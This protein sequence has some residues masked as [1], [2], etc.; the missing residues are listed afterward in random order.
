MGACLRRGGGSFPGFMALLAVQKAEKLVSNKSK[1]IGTS[2]GRPESIHY[3]VGK[4]SM[5]GLTG[6]NPNKS[7]P[8]KSKQA[9]SKLQE[10]N[11]TQRVETSQTQPNPRRK[12]KPKRVETK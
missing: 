5:L 10:T 9:K 7:N 12:I 3:E 6:R 11:Q 1:P 8:S 4:L 2:P